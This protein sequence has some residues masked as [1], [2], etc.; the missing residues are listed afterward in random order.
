[1][2]NMSGRPGLSLFDNVLV[3]VANV[4]LNIWLIPQYGIEGSAV[5][6]AISLALVN[7]LRVVQ[8]KKVL[9]MFPFGIGEA[10]ALVAAFAAAGTTLAV[11]NWR[12]EVNFVTAVI[13]G[14]VLACTYLVVVVILGVT[15]DDRLVWDALRGRRRLV[16]P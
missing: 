16:T 8:V 3:L 5:A 15:E 14:V 13:G 12:A 1:M 6:W 9:G 7:V 2:L 10:K 11:Q 4:A